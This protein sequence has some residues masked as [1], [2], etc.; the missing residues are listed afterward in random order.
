MSRAFTHGS[1]HTTTDLMLITVRTPEMRTSHTSLKLFVH[2]YT[3]LNLH[4]KTFLTLPYFKKTD[5]VLHFT[6]PS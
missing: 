2:F 4:V 6:L 1:E 5:L 3:N